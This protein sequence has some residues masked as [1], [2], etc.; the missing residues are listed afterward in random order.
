MYDSKFNLIDGVRI[1]LGNNVIN[2]LEVYSQDKLKE[3][4]YLLQLWC[5]YTD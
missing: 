1:M 4:I 3:D 2:C 5:N